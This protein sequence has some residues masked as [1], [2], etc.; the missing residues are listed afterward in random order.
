[1]IRISR[2]SGAGLL[3]F[4]VMGVAL[5]TSAVAA[6]TPPPRACFH[7]SDWDGGWSAPD[8]Q[9][10]LLRM[11]SLDIWRVDLERASRTVDWDDSYLV[12]AK[13]GPDRVCYPNDLHLRTGSV[14]GAAMTLRA[15]SISKLTKDEIAAL[16]K[17][18]RP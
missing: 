1:M 6:E 5:G 12:S 3:A 10:I 16:P 17:K 18:D 15:R 9:T 4:T 14:T 8:Q 7:L 13:L 2:L 11:R